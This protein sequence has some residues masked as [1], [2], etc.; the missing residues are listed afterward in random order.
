[1]TKMVRIENADI[2]SYK[3]R[4]RAQTRTADGKWVDSDEKPTEL[5]QPTMIT[6]ATIYKERRLIVEE[7]E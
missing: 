1:M 6:T 4:V 7:Y 3:V 2:S 5:P